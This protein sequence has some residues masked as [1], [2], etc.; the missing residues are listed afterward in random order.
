MSKTALA[1]FD[2]PDTNLVTPK[3]PTH[4]VVIEDVRGSL[5]LK[6]DGSQHRRYTSFY[7]DLQN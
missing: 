6:K 2:R 7:E 3:S 1:R 5:D 4:V